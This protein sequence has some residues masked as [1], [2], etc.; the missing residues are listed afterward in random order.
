MQRGEICLKLWKN[1]EKP[2]LHDEE[3]KFLIIREHCQLG[4]LNAFAPS[5][6]FQQRLQSLINSGECLRPRNLPIS[7]GCKHNQ[8]MNIHNIGHPRDNHKNTIG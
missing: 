7:E 1:L 8:K 4:V 5:I 2:E 6:F 3:P